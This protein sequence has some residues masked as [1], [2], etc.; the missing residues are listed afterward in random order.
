MPSSRPRRPSCSA[1]SD[2]AA[3]RARANGTGRPVG[4]RGWSV[5]GGGPAPFQGSGISSA[6]AT[7]RAAADL[8]ISS[9]YS[10]TDSRCS[11]ALRS[12]RQAML[13]GMPRYVHV[14]AM[15]T[16]RQGRVDGSSGRR[17]RS[18]PLNAG[19]G[20]TGTGCPWGNSEAPSLQALSTGVSQCPWTAS[21]KYSRSRTGSSKRWSRAALQSSADTSPT[22][23]AALRYLSA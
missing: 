19:V 12:G 16:S 1:A 2:N 15:Y 11:R 18:L 10:R 4:S 23:I 3:S 13:R 7:L 8:R 14:T 5:R 9:R 20:R 21:V 22:C 17:S 6:Y